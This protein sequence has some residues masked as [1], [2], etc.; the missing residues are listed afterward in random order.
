MRPR[1]RKT[2]KAAQCPPIAPESS[3]DDDDDDDDDDKFHQVM[4]NLALND[5]TDLEAELHDCKHLPF[6]RRNLRKVSGDEHAVESKSVRVRRIYD[7]RGK[8]Y[9]ADCF[10]FDWRCPLCRFKMRFQT[11]NALKG[12]LKLHHDKWRWNW[13]VISAVRASSGRYSFPYVMTFYI[14]DHMTLTLEVPDTLKSFGRRFVCRA[15]EEL[16]LCSSSES[17]CAILLLL[18]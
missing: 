12:H 2:I 10:A 11:E 3:S 15:S 9:A 1:G 4:H 5:L 6:L 14:Q 8:E 17:S 16:M 7:F 13:S 18:Q